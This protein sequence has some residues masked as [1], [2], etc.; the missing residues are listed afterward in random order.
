MIRLCPPLSL[1]EKGKRENN[2]DFIYPPAS[3]G[4]TAAN[5]RFFLVCDGVGGAEKGEDASRIV[6]ES[7][8]KSLSRTE[9][10]CTDDIEMALMNAEYDLEAYLEAHP[11]VT[12]MA[13]TLT[14]AAFNPSE[15]IVAHVGDSRIYHF[16]QEQMLLKTADHSLVN[17][18]VINNIITEEQAMNHPKRHVVSRAIMGRQRPAR[19]DITHISD[20]RAGDYF[21]LCTDGILESFSDT[22]LTAVLNEKNYSN[23]DK[24]MHVASVCRENS[25]DNFSA[26]L[27]QIAAEAAENGA[28]FKEEKPAAV[29][30]ENVNGIIPRWVA[31]T[32]IIAAIALVI[33]AFMIF[34]KKQLPAKKDTKPATQPGVGHNGRNIHTLD[35]IILS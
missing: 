27:V 20:V 13:T 16:R 11:E 23:E 25:K 18:M 26:Y 22:A 30:A 31:Y 34:R 17:E 24:M 3:D 10:I 14:L 28:G 33:S 21:L 19:L 8:A 35:E 32:F 4:A 5:S 15:V 7:F 29:K 12:G 1:S 2:E 9:V 6:C